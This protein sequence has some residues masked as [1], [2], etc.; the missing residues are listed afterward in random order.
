MASSSVHGVHEFIADL[1][2]VSRTALRDV[3]AITKRAA[4]NIKTELVTE[5]QG[6]GSFSAIAPTISYEQHYGRGKVAYDI[7]PDKDRGGAASL[8]GIAYFG[9]A[10]GGGGKLDFE[11]PLERETPRMMQHLS[12]YLGGIL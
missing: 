4:Q 10:H 9:G 8:A 11:G 3:D 7:G 12:Q 2:R 5:A 1:Q 6:S